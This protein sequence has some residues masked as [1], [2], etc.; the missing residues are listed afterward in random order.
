MKKKKKESICLKKKEKKR[1][2]N[3]TAGWHGTKNSKNRDYFFLSQGKHSCLC[4]FELACPAAR[5]LFPR[6]PQGWLPPFT[7]VTA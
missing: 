6:D 3:Q 1:K 5:M 7:E 4:A 2:E